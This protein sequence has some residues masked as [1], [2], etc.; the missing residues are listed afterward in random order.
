MKFDPK[1][2]GPQQLTQ[3]DGAYT[4]SRFSEMRKTL[5][6][7]PYYKAWGAPGEL[8][9]PTFGASLSGGFS[10]VF[11]P[12]AGVGA[13][14]RPPIVRSNPTPTCA[15]VPTGGAFAGCSIPTASASSAAGKST[16]ERTPVTPATPATSKTAAPG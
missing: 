16:P 9:L 15:G 12:S 11:F 13:F 8:P 1:F 2:Y 14:S 6:A 7:N 10:A 3:E 4:G 5:F